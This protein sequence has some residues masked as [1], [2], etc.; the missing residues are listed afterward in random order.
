GVAVTPDGQGV[1]VAN[2]N[3]NTV[4]V[5]DTATNTVV[6]AIP[7]G[8]GPVA[9]GQFIGTVSASAPAVVTTVPVGQPAPTVPVTTTIFVQ[10]LT[11]MTLAF[12]ANF[13]SYDVS[14]V[15]TTTNTVV[16]MVDVEVEPAGIAVSPS[17]S[18]VY[19]GSAGGNITVIDT[20]T[21]TVV[22]T[23][24]AG[25]RLRG[26]AVT[27]DG[28]RVYAASNF[29]PVSVIDTATNTV[30]ATVDVGDSPFGVAVNPDG[31]RVYVTNR[32]DNTVLVVDT[33]SNTVVA[34]V[35]VGISPV[36]V[37]VHPN[38]S[39]V[40][41]ANDGSD[42]VSV[43]DTASNTVVAT[44]GVGSFP[45]GVAVA[46]DG[47]RVYVA[48]FGSD[49]VSVLDAATNLV[50]ATV[51]VGGSPSGVSVTPDGSRVYVANRNSST[52]SVLDTV[53][54]TVIAT[55]PVGA[56]PVNFGQFI[57]TV[58][59]ATSVPV[60]VQTLL[61]LVPVDPVDLFQ[62]QVDALNQGDVA[63]VLATL[64][65]DA[66]LLSLFCQPCSGREAI[67]RNIEFQVA[68]QFH[69]TL[70]R[71]GS[72]DIN[73]SVRHRDIV[74]NTAVGQL[75]VRGDV[76]RAPG[77]QRV[78]GSFLVLVRGDK[79]TFSRITLDPSDPETAA[80]LAFIQARSQ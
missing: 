25:D 69:L 16:A 39:R 53:T 11:P 30:I 49:T 27:P 56:S 70:T 50:I 44:V 38:G 79:I 60:L 65:D 4:S 7:V 68:N 63:G 24:P 43:V 32:F 36:G 64:A 2:V 51:E 47:S 52:V 66:V 40:Y 74:A 46:P 35:G 61:P 18:R 62:Q 45:S 77:F 19:V 73:G 17:T 55:V 1:Y 48:N 22:A 29:G 21:N 31:T 33:A 20:T 14:V 12:I 80:F 41:V 13:N 75:E 37:A 34:T 42:T 3:G 5:L 28:S 71:I 58:L 67:Q 26:V 6:A 23:V 59:V 10:A 8:A 15:D 9:F 72:F 54:N 76:F 57:G 78:V